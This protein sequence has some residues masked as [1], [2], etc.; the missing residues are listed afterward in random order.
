MNSHDPSYSYALSV[1]CDYYESFDHD[2]YIRPYRD[3][4]DATCASL[5]KTINEMIDKMVETMKEN[6]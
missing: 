4:I 2:V 6:C 5:G 1:L 3:F